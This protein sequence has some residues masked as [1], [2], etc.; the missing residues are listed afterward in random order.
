MQLN[1]PPFSRV[2]HYLELSR[3]SGIRLPSSI[4]SSKKAK[5]ILPFASFQVLDCTASALF[6]HSVTASFILLYTGS[7]S[8]ASSG[9]TC[10]IKQHLWT[11]SFWTH[12]LSIYHIK[13]ILPLYED[14][15]RNCH[16]PQHILF[17]SV[18]FCE[19]K[20]EIRLFNCLSKH[21]SCTG[22]KRKRPSAKRAYDY[23]R[24]ETSMARETKKRSILKRNITYE[25]TCMKTV[26]I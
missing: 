26:L 11:R 14:W 16:S 22:F 12:C 21:R 15:Y 19:L 2:K 17:Q 9:T 10:R 7:S 8:T 25:E 13:W 5:P 3:L 1:L 20:L 23:G 18:N 4:N 24:V 6:S